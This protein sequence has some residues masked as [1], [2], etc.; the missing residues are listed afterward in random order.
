VGVVEGTFIPERNLLIGADGQQYRATCVP[1]VRRF[2]LKHPDRAA[3]AR[4]LVCWPRTTK[5]GVE[6]TVTDAPTATE[7]QASLKREAGWFRVAGVVTNQRSRKNKVVVRVVRSEPAPPEQKRQSNYRPHLLFLEGRVAPAANFVNHHATF[8]CQ[9]KDKGLVIRSV[10]ER[11]RIKPEPLAA[12]G[13]QW[14]W[15]FH[16]SKGSLLDLKAFN[17]PEQK[18]FLVQAPY[19][20]TLGEG[21]QLLQQLIDHRKAQPATAEEALVTDRLGM[22]LRRLR[23]YTARMGDFELFD[24]LE[25]TGLHVILRRITIEAAPLAPAPAKKAKPKA[26]KAAAPAPVGQAPEELKPLADLLLQGWPDTLL[27]SAP[28]MSPAALKSGVAGL[29]ACGWY[30]ALTEEEQRLA[31]AS[32]Q[33]K[34]ALKQRN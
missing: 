20:Q 31:Q 22:I 15:P 14:P 19:Q 9:L 32:Y 7:R 6:L 8:R 28:G 26:T 12:G 25:E 30:D 10:E 17:A 24:L 27:R 3:S 33:L 34:K 1:G 5:E 11:Q 23:T 13:V 21:L 4:Y 2:F 29:L 16:A 18:T